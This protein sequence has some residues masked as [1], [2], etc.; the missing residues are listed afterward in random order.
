M[1]IVFK[2]TT[3]SNLQTDLTARYLLTSNYDDSVSGDSAT[4][5]SSPDGVNSEG[6]SSSQGYLQMPSSFASAM[7]WDTGDGTLSWWNTFDEVPPTNNVYAFTD[8]EGGD[9]NDTGAISIYLGNDRL[10]FYRNYESSQ[11]N[12]GPSMTR[13]ESGLDYTSPFQQNHIVLVKDTASS[14]IKVYVDGTEVDSVVWGSTDQW[15][16]SAS[17]TWYIGNYNIGTY[18][19]WPGRIADVA[20]WKGRALSASEVTQL[21]NKGQGGSY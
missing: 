4:A 16:I 17:R 11:G 20:V 3:S 1:P 18:Y 7:F 6:F 12:Y 5:V 21:Y 19:D 8:R 15:V 9:S 10:Y 14:T 13:A 2:I